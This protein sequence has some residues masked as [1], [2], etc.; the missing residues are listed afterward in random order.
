VHQENVNQGW[1]LP[2]SPAS[3]QSRRVGSVARAS[4]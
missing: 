1:E 2:P 3:C 4:S